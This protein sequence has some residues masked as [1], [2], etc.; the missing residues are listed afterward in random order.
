MNEIKKELFDKQIFSG[1]NFIIIR[2][3]CK[4][5]VIEEVGESELI[6]K[7]EFSSVTKAKEEF[8]DRLKSLI[9]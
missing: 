7:K 5:T 6:D 2:K 8:A 1:D 4:V 3:G 9:G